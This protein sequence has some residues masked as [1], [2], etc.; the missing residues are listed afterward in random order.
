MRGV[1]GATSRKLPS[2]LFSTVA[3][4]SPLLPSNCSSVRS[5]PIIQWQRG[6]TGNTWKLVAALVSALR[7]HGNGMAT[8]HR[9]NTVGGRIIYIKITNSSLFV[10]T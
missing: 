3:A 2:L 5:P 9:Y 6:W 10:I 8:Q 4:T 1:S 7:Q